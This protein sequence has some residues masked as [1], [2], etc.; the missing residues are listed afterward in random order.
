VDLN[1]Y[2]TE[3]I[4]R[5]PWTVL[6]QDGSTA[7]EGWVDVDIAVV[8]QGFLLAVTTTT[9]EPGETAEEATE[10]AKL[11]TWWPRVRNKTARPGLAG[12]YWLWAGRP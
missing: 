12:G 4:E 10:R 5:L 8:T 11:T 6:R 7:G 3:N 1:Q 9:V 2:V